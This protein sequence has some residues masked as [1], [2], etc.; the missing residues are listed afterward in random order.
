MASIQNVSI[1][2][3]TLN[4]TIKGDYEK[5]LD[6]SLIN[7]IRRTLLNDISTVAF[8]VNDTNPKPDIIIENNSSSLHN[9]MIKERISLIPLYIDPSK[10]Y[11]SYL[12]YCSVKHDKK[13]PFQFV[14]A[15]DIEIYPLNDNLNKRVEDLMDE[16]IETPDLEKENLEEILST[17]NLENYNMKK[18]LSQ[19]QKDDIYR[20]FIYN[21]NKNYC[22]LI[23]LKNTNTEDVFQEITFYG[24]PTINTTKTH[25]RYQSVS[26]ATYQ[27][28]IDEELVSSII[29]EQIELKKIES[30]KI[31]EFTN[32]FMINDSERYYHR[33]K[34]NE[35]YIF[36]F[37][38]KSV[39]YLTSE[40]L[41]QNAITI[42]NDKLDDL[43]EG[44]I[45]LLQEKDSN[46]E[47]SQKNEYIHIY[48]LYNYDHTI[49]SIIQSHISRHSITDKSLL[50]VCGYKKVH[51]LEECIHL[52]CSMNPNHKSFKLDDKIRSQQVTQFLI[53]E[54]IQIKSIYLSLLKSSQKA[55]Q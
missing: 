22:L 17:N 48:E 32:K 34:D 19:K 37:K 50:Q 27:F 3:D 4:F 11:K 39:H 52:I 29:Q 9:E 44:L 8:N 42:I 20:P 23:E 51:P 21:K 7:G 24:S 6:K 53:D 46:I 38:I 31:E 5:G 2:K 1:Q 36:D 12:F 15:N 10:F 47:L 40:N 30:E 25:S 54:I 14:T 43:K 35:P 49:G 16:S 13:T 28:S 45:L 55:F 26:C 18:P 41:F 33:D